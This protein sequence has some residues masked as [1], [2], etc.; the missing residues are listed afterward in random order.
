MVEFQRMT[1]KSSPVPP[2]A[3]IILIRHAEK[4]P[5]P[6]DPHL[7]QAGVKRARHLVSFIT[8]NPAMKKFGLPVATFATQTTKD[9]HGVRTQETLATLARSLKL[10]VQTPCHGKNYEKLAKRILKTRAYAKKTVLICWN[11]EEIS[12]L[13]AALGVKPQPPKWKDSVFDQVYVI[14]YHDGKAALSTCRYNCK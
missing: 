4:P 9:H 10:R 8:N 1:P 5:D 14:S 13:A 12:S 11:H 3:Q 2:P 6:D 7:S